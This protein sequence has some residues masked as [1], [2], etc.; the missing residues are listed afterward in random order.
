[1]LVRLNR[2]PRVVGP[3]RVLE[4]WVTMLAS[5]GIAVVLAS[6]VSLAVVALPL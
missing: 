4:G 6:V 2:D 1:M 3:E 5:A